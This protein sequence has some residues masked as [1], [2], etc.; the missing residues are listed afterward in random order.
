[1]ID[2]VGLVVALEW[3]AR[4]FSRQT[5]I[6]TSV[7]SDGKLDELS[8]AHRICIYRCVQEALTNCAKHAHAKSIRIVIC[9]S[10]DGV[11]VTIE[12]DGIGM[13]RN[14]RSDGGL[15]LLGMRERVAELNGELRVASR[16]CG[17]TA[18]ILE[19]PLSGSVLV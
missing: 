4:Q 1:M 2:D 10:G 5:E 15:G 14:T 11:N 12:D 18:I 13:D 9:A 7:E 6:P 8:E 19:I 16:E 3:Q 17:G